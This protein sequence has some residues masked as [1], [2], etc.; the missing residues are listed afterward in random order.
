MNPPRKT[1]RHKFL[2]ILLVTLSSAKL[3]L[4]LILLSILLSVVGLVLPQEG[5]F[6]PD[7][8]SI[9]QEAHP[10]TTAVLNPLGM[11]H[12]FHSSLFLALIVLLGVNTLT[13]T[14][15]RLKREGG[16]SALRGTGSIRR[17][18]FLSLHVCL[19]LLFGGGF[20][21]ASS[22]LDGYIVLTEGQAFKE[23]HT[24]YLRLVEGPLRRE[25]HKG[26]SVRLNKLDVVYE[27]KRFH[28][29]T[30]AQLDVQTKDGRRSEAVVKVNR[31]V[32]IQGL[33]FTLDDIGFSPRLMIWEKATQRLLLNSFIALKTFRQGRERE[34]RDFL[35]LSFLEHRIIVTIYPKHTRAEG[36]LKKTGDLP[37]NPLLLIEIQSEPGEAISNG[38][39]ALGE[40]IDLGDYTFGFAELRR[41]SSFK[42]VEDKGY[43]LVWIA[44]WMGIAALLLRYWPDLRLWFSTSESG[45]KDSKES[46]KKSAY[47]KDDN[48]KSAALFNKTS[49]PLESSIEKQGR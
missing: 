7:D 33:A 8:I 47:A 13:C 10:V 12:V 17:W 36:L 27:N 24:G 16:F 34:Y 41:W 49:N 2:N 46:G 15:L 31:P 5:V 9:W 48:N 32:S 26:F 1:V 19:L 35:P 44:L 22:R 23:E 25:D 45:F 3:A 11:F 21:S 40:K 20:W 38:D 14:F 30:T 4:V 39:V 37:E 42:V 43:T 28:T 6:E 29:Q 18:G